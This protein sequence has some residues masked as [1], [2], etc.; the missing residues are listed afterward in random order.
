M[1]LLLTVI[2]IDYYLA[3][4][5]NINH[6]FALLIEINDDSVNEFLQASKNFT[7]TTR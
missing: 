7:A 6:L 1:H 5:T 3:N 4:K 2:I